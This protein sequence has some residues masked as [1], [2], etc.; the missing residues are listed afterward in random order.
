MIP[1]PDSRRYVK[2][3][4][5]VFR[6]DEVLKDMGWWHDVYFDTEVGVYLVANFPTE[7][8]FFELGIP[9]LPGDAE[10]TVDNKTYRVRIYEA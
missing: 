2:L 7:G 5:R 9:P 6:F 8:R 10:V 1:S 3:A 4:R